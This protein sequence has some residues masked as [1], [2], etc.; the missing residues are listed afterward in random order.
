LIVCQDAK[1]KPYISYPWENLQASP[2][3]HRWGLRMSRHGLSSV[4]NGVRNR[5]TAVALSSLT[6]S[7]SQ[8]THWNE[9]FVLRYATYARQRQLWSSAAK[10]LHTLGLAYLQ[11]KAWQDEQRWSGGEI[12]RLD[13]RWIFCSSCKI[14]RILV[15]GVW[16]H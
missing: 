12:Y 14:N 13:D 8:S 2:K 10:I 6:R 1:T 3:R 4:S 11:H 15:N 5:T 16:C 9:P 7:T